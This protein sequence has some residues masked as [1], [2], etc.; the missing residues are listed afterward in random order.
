MHG[1][2]IPDKATDDMPLEE[3]PYLE[4]L[5]RFVFGKKILLQPR[6]NKRR[7]AT[8]LGRQRRRGRLRA[9]KRREGG[10]GSRTMQ[11]HPTSRL[12]GAVRGED[13][14]AKVHKPCKG[15]DPLDPKGRT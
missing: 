10:G 15:F 1:V 2:K 14:K 4:M 5:Y 7:K 8:K 9:R 6:N 12:A 3:L 13:E 11:S